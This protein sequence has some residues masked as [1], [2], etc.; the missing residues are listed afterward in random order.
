MNTEKD[1][2]IKYILIGK[3]DDLKEIGEYPIQTNMDY[4]KD[5]RTIFTSYC[6]TNIQSK[7]D[8]RNKVKA[9]HTNNNHYFYISDQRIFFISVVD[10]SY[11]ETNVFKMFDEIQK[12]NV[13]L[14]RD[15][16]GKLNSIGLSKLKEIY[17]SFQNASESSIFKEINK[18]IDGLKGDMRRNITK[19]VSN[20]EDAEKLKDRA[21]AIKEGSNAFYEQANE[22]KKVSWWQNMKLWLIIGAVIVLLI[23]I[24]VIPIVVS[25][26]KDK[27][28]EKIIIIN[29]SNSTNSTDI[30]KRFLL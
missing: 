23:L 28:E 12:E 3:A 6:S 27:N 26:K 9:K 4:A 25:S 7:I 1:N 14:L 20:V 2:K 15:D 13:H 8:S 18:D 30:P 17:N 29:V 11:P 19:I 5:C 10:A 22:L 16:K 21:E 24:I